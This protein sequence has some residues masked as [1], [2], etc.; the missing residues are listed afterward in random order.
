[1]PSFT[2]MGFS[3]QT[4]LCPHANALQCD[5]CSYKIPSSCYRMQQNALVVC[6][7]GLAMHRDLSAVS[8]SSV[9]PVLLP[10]LLL[11]QACIAF[12]CVFYIAY[13]KL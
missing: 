8:L 2:V 11:I 4:D 3:L 1:M 12:A 13:F 9:P 5:L 6:R 10:P 7:G